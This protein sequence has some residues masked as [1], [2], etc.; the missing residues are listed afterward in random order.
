HSGKICVMGNGLVVDP[1]ALQTEIEEL[2]AVGI[3]VRD[4]LWIS[5]RAHLIL[6]FHRAIE[7]ASEEARGED[8]VGTTLRGIG[9]AYEDKMGRRGLRVGD[10]LDFESFRRRALANLAAA[11][12]QL[13]C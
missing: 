1:M 6:P 5:N 7:Q 12:K 11:R 4:R 8:R 9:P 2:R 13:E 3:E 10:L